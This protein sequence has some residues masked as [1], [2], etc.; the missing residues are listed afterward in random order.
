VVCFGKLKEE[1]EQSLHEEAPKS[2]GPS[3]G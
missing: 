3:L 1:G 2:A